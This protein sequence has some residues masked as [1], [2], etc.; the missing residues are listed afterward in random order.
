MDFVHTKMN[1]ELKK[2]ACCGVQEFIEIERKCF[3]SVA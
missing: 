2:V 1:L 3:K